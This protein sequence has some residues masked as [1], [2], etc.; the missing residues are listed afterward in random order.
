M[1][2]AFVVF[3]ATVTTVYAQSFNF[4]MNIPPIP[5]SSITGR[6][7]GFNECVN[8]GLCPDN[9]EQLH[10][11]YVTFAAR[12]N[13]E[14]YSPVT[15]VVTWNAQLHA[16]QFPLKIAT[17]ASFS[18]G[19]TI[20][21]IYQQLACACLSPSIGSCSNVCDGG[22]SPLLDATAAVASGLTIDA[23]G[24]WNV[25]SDNC[26]LKVTQVSGV[27]V[28]LP[29]SSSWSVNPGADCKGWIDTFLGF[30][31][32]TFNP[33]LISNAID[34]QLQQSFPE[35]FMGLTLQCPMQP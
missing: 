29:S 25:G 11:Q 22:Q 3:A 31:V 23:I 6:I 17:N 1:S 12:D 21:G 5:A 19:L 15:I 28:G 14:F 2:R 20:G 7:D 13:V 18:I 35:Y 16:W 9:D 32:K 4:T 26:T 34:A 33:S 10:V 8:C 30:F 24:T 27:N